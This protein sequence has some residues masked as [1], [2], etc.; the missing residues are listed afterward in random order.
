MN[1]INFSGWKLL[2]VFALFQA[3]FGHMPLMAQEF[4]FTHC[5]ANLSENGNTV[6]LDIGYE[7]D[8]LYFQYARVSNFDACNGETVEDGTLTILILPKSLDFS[9]I[10]LPEGYYAWAVRAK[11]N[12]Q[13][14][15]PWTYSNI[16]IKGPYT[17][18]V[19]FEFCASCTDHQ[20]NGSLITAGDCTSEITYAKSVDNGPLHFRILMPLTYLL[21][22]DFPTY[23]DITIPEINIVSDTTIMVYVYYVDLNESTDDKPVVYPNPASDYVTVIWQEQIS[24]LTIVDLNGKTVYQKLTSGLNYAA[25]FSV[26]ELNPGNYF[27]VLQS[28]G[29]S[30]VRKLIIR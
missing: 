17:L 25:T 10:N 2:A 5:I 29:Q 20:V 26:R 16:I 9:L 28:K 8:A 7:G 3:G 12:E 23:E 15:S 14:Y 27:L 18:N 4:Y 24:Q 11:I 21:T 6:N 1:N 19:Q 13:E 22:L 30:T